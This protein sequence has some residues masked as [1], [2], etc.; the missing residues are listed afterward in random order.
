MKTWRKIIVCSIM[1]GAFSASGC[2]NVFDI[3]DQ[4]KDKKRSALETAKKKW[5]DLGAVDYTIEQRL[6]CFCPY[7]PGGYVLRVENS[8]IVEVK[9]ISDGQVM[10]AEV[11]SAFK[12][13][14]QLFEFIEAN[15]EGSVETISVEYDEDYGYP[16]SVFIDR[17]IQIADEE[18]RWETGK[19]VII[20]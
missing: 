5:N 2:K 6:L 18:K 20:R 14:E 3:F 1:I 13:V 7:N 12:S 15:P 19:L 10:S 17:D 8:V 11:A 9:Q 4:E 16:K